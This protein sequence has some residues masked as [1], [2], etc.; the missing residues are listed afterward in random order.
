MKERWQGH[1]WSQ[2]CAA[3]SDSRQRCAALSRS[4]VCRQRELSDPLAEVP[5]QARNLEPGAVAVDSATGIRQAARPEPR[6]SI[7]FSWL[8]A[9]L[10]RRVDHVLV[11]TDAGRFVTM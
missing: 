8:V 6:C 11:V 5:D 3:M 1:V 10:V 2:T 9:P 7:T 4:M